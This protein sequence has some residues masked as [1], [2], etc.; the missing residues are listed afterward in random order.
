VTAP[1]RDQ[2]ASGLRQFRALLLVH[3][4]TAA[5]LRERPPGPHRLARLDATAA[6]LLD[7][8]CS[9]A[10]APGIVRLLFA[11]V[12]DATAESDDFFELGVDVILDGLE[13][14]L[15]R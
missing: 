1:W 11:H 13:Q 3:R 15:L 8:G 12:L 7:A 14:R 2:L 4:D 10:E 6:I 9:P 5:L